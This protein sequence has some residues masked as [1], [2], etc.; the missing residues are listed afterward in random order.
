[1]RLIL[2]HNPTSGEEEHGRRDLERLLESA[3]HEVTYRSL[4][5][6]DWA[7]VLAEPRDL[8]VVAGG[9]GSVRKVFT[10][11]DGGSTTATLFPTGSANN[12]ART[13]G[14]ET[15]DPT[16]LLAAWEPAVRVPFDVWEVSAPWGTSR[17]V[18]SVGG[19][20]FADV[21]TAAD[22]EDADPSGEE[23]VDFGLRL[24]LER[25]AEVAAGTWELE[26]DG[27][28][29]REELIGVAALNVREL[30]ANLPLAPGADPGD[31][32]LDVVLM[33]P[34]DRE[35]LA[36]YVEARLHDEAGEAPS[37]E[38]RQARQVVLEPPA[39]AGLHVDDV[40]PAW[41]DSGSPWV[42]VRQ[43]DVRLEVVV[44]AVQADA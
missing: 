17:I 5:D 21:L 6:D 26:L 30:G 23:K 35:P 42:E 40:L 27:T 14:Y 4:K 2:L 41:D 11:L 18:E 25:L 8:I 9:D 1:V 12:I 32:L 37:L 15:D 33:R 28:R 7:D 24:V 10:A 19:G 16:R 20:L 36:R 43:A 31:G 34:A 3:G 29:V 44:P 22:E 39:D 38:S 13:L